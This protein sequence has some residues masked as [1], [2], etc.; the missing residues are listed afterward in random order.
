M[1]ITLAQAIIGV[2]VGFGAWGKFKAWRAKRKAAKAAKKLE[3][4][5][6]E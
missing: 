5:R 1:S 2:K 3:A 4:V 6:G